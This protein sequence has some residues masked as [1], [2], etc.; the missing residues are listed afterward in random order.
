MNKYKEALW[1]IDF[2]MHNRVKPKYLQNV[3][4]KNFEIL[5]EL[6]EKATS[7]KAIVVKGWENLFICPSCNENI[8]SSKIFPTKYCPYCGQALYWGEEE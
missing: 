1:S 6:V 7:K 5:H 4:D 3:E 8:T 2:T